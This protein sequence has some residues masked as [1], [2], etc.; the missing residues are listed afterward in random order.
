MWLQVRTSRLRSLARLVQDR[1][2]VAA[3]EFAIVAPVLILLF[4]GVFQLT[5]GMSASRKVTVTA[6]TLAD[7]TS[8]YTSVSSTT[9]ET[10]LHVSSYVMSPYAPDSGTYSLAAVTTDTAGVSRVT[11]SRKL[12]NGTTAAGKPVGSIVTL[13]SSAAVPGTM[14]IVA[15]VTYAYKPVIAPGLFGEFQLGEQIFM[16]PRRSSSIPLE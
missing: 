12:V 14:I 13:P 10:I 2:G 8:Q 6:R 16:M 11:W 9:L 7:L 5:D 15:D 3:T 1:A 4:V